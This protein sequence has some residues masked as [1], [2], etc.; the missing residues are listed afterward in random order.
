MSVHDI[1]TL[2][3]LVEPAAGEVENCG[4]PVAAAEDAFDASRLAAFF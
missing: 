3:Q 2:L 1:H 4:F